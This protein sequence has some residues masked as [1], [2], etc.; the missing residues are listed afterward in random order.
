MFPAEYAERFTVRPGL[1][2][3]WQVRGRSRLGTAEMLELDREY[4]R[5]RRL[6]TDVRILLATLPSLIRGDGAR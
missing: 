1:T 6:G 5:T 4:V 2:G 3:L